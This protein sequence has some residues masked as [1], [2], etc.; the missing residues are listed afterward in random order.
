MANDNE[1]GF[2]NAYTSAPFEGTVQITTH[3]GN[4]IARSSNQINCV[5]DTS[6]KV[7][8]A[9]KRAISLSEEWPSSWPESLKPEN[10]EDYIYVNW[11]TDSEI[12]GNQTFDMKVEENAHT[13]VSQGTL[14]LGYK[15]S[16]SGVLFK[17]DG[18]ER[19]EQTLQTN[20][21]VSNG[22]AFGGN[23]YVAYPKSNFENNNT[24]KIDNSCFIPN[25][26]GDLS[27]F[28]NGQRTHSEKNRG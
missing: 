27:F 20:G 8:S 13:N 14:L 17:G 4:T 2:N 6:E 19:I 7:E 3:L 1:P 18:S 12:Y 5:I 26:Q 9:S 10:S 25:A 24:Y 22:F 23:V 15:D 21:Y 11:Y 28:Q 16:R